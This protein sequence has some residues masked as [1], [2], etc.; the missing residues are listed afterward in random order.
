MQ[1]LFIKLSKSRALDKA[2]N[3]AAY[4]RRAAINL[5]FDRRGKMKLKASSLDGICEPASGDNSPTA[6][7]IRSEELAAILDAAGR[8]EGASRQAFVMRY[9]QQEPYDYIAEQL[10][11]TPHQV[12]ALCSKALMR[13][14]DLLGTDKSPVF[15]KEVH[16]V[17]D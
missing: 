5:A 13:L 2:V 12:R 11:K 4:I 8:L 17:E 7:L 1:E 6:E 15:E 10:D 9:I 3:P 14:R 16:D